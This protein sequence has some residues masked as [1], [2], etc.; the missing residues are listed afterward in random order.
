MLPVG[1]PFRF[2]L[3]DG[4]GG[5]LTIESTLSSGFIGVPPATLLPGGA[6]F[7]RS[8]VRVNVN[9]MARMKV[10][11]APTQRGLKANEVVMAAQ[12]ARRREVEDSGTKR[13]ARTSALDAS[14][15]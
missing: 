4:A 11:N 10:A 14:R 2:S 7:G 15:R 9:A 5:L 8:I 12:Q 1:T 6:G 3:L 13:G